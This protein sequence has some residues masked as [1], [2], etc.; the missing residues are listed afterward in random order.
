MIA[1][2][3]A[4]TFIDRGSQKIS[5]GLPE[6]VATGVGNFTN[7]QFPTPTVAVFEHRRHAWVEIPGLQI[8]H[9]NE[10]YQ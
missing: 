10:I 1:P 6:V 2:A 8:Q 5:E 4:Y 7:P 3:I 9:F